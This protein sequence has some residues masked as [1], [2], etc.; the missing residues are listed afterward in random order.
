MRG[1]ATGT[2]E[3]AALNGVRGLAILGVLMVH[4]IAGITFQLP[5]DSADVVGNIADAGVFG[6]DLFF[7]LS[8]FLITGILLRRRGEPHYFRNFYA[9]RFL[10]LFPLYYGYLAAIAFLLPLFHRI[11]HSSMN[12]YAGSWWWYL[13]YLSNWKEGGGAHDPMLGHFWSLAVEEQFYLVWPAVVLALSRRRLAVFCFTLIVFSTTLRFVLAPGGAD[14]NTVYRLTVTRFDT[15]ATGALIAL[16]MQSARWRP[17]VLRWMRP[18]G[19]SAALAFVFL[20]WIA[21]GPQWTLPVIQLWS[22]LFAELAF[23][24]LV[25]Y[26]ASGPDG[27]LTQR[28]LMSAGRYSYAAY[29]LHV[30]IFEYGIN[31]EALLSRGS[32]GLTYRVSLGVAVVSIEWAVVFAVAA[33]SGRYFEGPLLKWKSRF[34]STTDRLS[35][36]HASPFGKLGS[37]GLD[38]GIVPLASDSRRTS[39]GLFQSALSREDRG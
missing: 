10:R 37:S 22:P 17:L 2:G 23:A 16:A 19:L 29:V 30:I 18:A 7:V 3:I 15:L 32:H 35:E 38:P 25:A 12:H 39:P 31:F 6:V 5:P 11:T 33:L 13:A 1:A 28:W 21:G 36:A 34:G 20:C 4:S 8:G 27:F 14:W 9:R 26:A 24:S